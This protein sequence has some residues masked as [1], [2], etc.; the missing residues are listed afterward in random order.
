M[1]VPGIR[2]TRAFWMSRVRLDDSLPLVRSR[3]GRL[4]HPRL[5]SRAP[6]VNLKHG[7]WRALAIKTSDPEGA[8]KAHPYH[9]LLEVGRSYSCTNSQAL[10]KFGWHPLQQLLALYRIPSDR[11]IGNERH[12]GWRPCSSNSKGKK[13][14]AIVESLESPEFRHT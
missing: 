5:S 6:G 7:T 8:R 12:A 3:T 2:P 10:D 11:N 1:E 14:P 9:P 13:R 4:L